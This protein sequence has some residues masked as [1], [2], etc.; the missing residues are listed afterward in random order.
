M[1]SGRPEP[2]SSSSDLPV[3]SVGDS[4]NPESA[5]ADA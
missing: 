5:Q 2:A 4:T 3:R 1:L